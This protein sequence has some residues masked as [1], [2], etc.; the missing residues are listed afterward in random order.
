LIDVIR[1][2]HLS[3]PVDFSR[4]ASYFTLDV[5][6]DIAFGTPFGYLPTEEDIYD[7]IKISQDSM[8][9]SQYIAI[10][11]VFVKLLASPILRRF[12]MPSVRDKV[13]LG[14]YME[15]IRSGHTA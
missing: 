5:I 15:Y 6:T 8:T 14:K 7:L 9:T 12:V 4:L 3:Q 11:P 13:G 1:S 2:R 10:F